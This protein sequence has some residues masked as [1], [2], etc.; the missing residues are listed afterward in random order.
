VESCMRDSQDWEGS[1]RRF[2]VIAL[3]FIRAVAILI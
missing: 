1:S 2:A 3:A